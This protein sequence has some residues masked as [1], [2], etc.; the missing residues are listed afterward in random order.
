MINPENPTSTREKILLIIKKKG[1]V[2]VNELT[3][4]LGIT[5]MGVRGHL[6]K[7]EQQK[8]ILSKDRR[9]KMGRP[10]Q[11]YFLTK[12]GDDYFPKAY[13]D[14]TIDMLAFLETMD[15][16]KTLDKLFDLRKEKM[17]Q[18]R[19]SAIGHLPFQKRLHAYCGILVKEGYMSEVEQNLDTVYCLNI[20]NCV[21]GEIA[22][23]Y[24]A[25]CL[26]ETEIVTELFPEAEIVL[27]T[28][29]TQNFYCRYF[30]NL[31]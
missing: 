18:K 23:L 19:K 22:V 10:Q 12:K 27:E 26:K 25:C 21:L 11:I 9:Q 16:G 6:T 3:L 7:L 15:Q 5:P 20:H 29:K 13:V 24:D 14:F 1:A 2:S 8:L 28:H 4:A 17:L 31:K 30:F